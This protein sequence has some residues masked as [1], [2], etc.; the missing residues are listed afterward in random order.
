M[1]D[2]STSRH[3]V[4]NILFSST[5]YTPFI[6]QDEI[7]LSRHSTVEKIIA[8][9][10]SAL[11]RLPGAVARSQITVSWFGSVYAGYTVLLARMMGKKSIVVVAGVDAA[12][13]KEIQY[14]IWLNPV[15][16]RVVRYAFLHANRVLVVDPSLGT[17]AARLAG[18]DGRNIRYIPFGYDSTVWVPGGAKVDMVLTVAACHDRW[19]MKKKG[20]DKIFAAAQ[21]M[22]GT[23][24][25]V[26]GIHPRLMPD[27]SRSVPGNVEV[28]PYVPQNQLLPYYQKAKVYCQPS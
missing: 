17:E 16:A 26:I 8:R 11:V 20:I 10:V 15:K 28:I 24:F 18:Y 3:T 5:L 25:C 7:L 27:V 1:S 19:R 23:R 12:K 6:E 4:P 2:L 13:E 21:A 14:G 9:G 22:P